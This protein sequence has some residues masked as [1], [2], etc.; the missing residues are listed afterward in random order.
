MT[1]LAITLFRKFP[2]RVG[3]VGKVYSW[4]GGENTRKKC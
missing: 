3:Q 2:S 4:F 1:E